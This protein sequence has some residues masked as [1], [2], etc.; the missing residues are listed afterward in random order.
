MDCFVYGTLTDPD[1]A[2]RVLGGAYEYGPAARLDGLHRVEGRY[3]TLGPGGS[4]GGRI[5]H[6]DHVAE[7]DAYEGVDS[8]LYVR[9]AV[10]HEAE[11][12]TERTVETYVG[13]P[14]RLDADVDWPGEG[15]FA[16]RVREYVEDGAVVARTPD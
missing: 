7:L 4:V 11:I 6:T 1:V 3:P 9:V 2:T 14:E 10:P 8:G 13:D 16:D 12:G 15:A 5:L